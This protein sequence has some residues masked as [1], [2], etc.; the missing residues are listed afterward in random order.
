LAIAGGVG[1]HGA[2]VGRGRERDGVGVGGGGGNG[3][4]LGLWKVFIIYAPH[5]I[6]VIAAIGTTV[7]AL[8]SPRSVCILA[9]VLQLAPLIQLQQ[10]ALKKVRPG[11][12]MAA[13]MMASALA[14]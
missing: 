13:L 11:Y 3:G 9:A 12:R 2:S 1:I 5:V 6:L 14:R 10:L 7:A 8:L 4:V